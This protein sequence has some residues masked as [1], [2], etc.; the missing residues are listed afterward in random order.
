LAID[1]NLIEQYVARVAQ[2]L[3]IVHQA[4]NENGRITAAGK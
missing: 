1:T 4:R 3:L 2:Q